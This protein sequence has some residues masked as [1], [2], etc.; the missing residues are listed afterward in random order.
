MRLAYA[1]LLVVLAASWGCERESRASE[2][3]EKTA[4]GRTIEVPP[5]LAKPEPEP[6]FQQ[7]YSLVDNRHLAHRFD[8]HGLVMDLG[9]AG[10]LKYMQG[11]WNSTWYRGRDGEGFRYGQPRGVSGTLRF[12]LWVPSASAETQGWKLGIRL[13]PE[14]NQRCDLFIASA[15]G[16]ERKFASL[17]EIKEGWNEYVVDLPDGLEV[18]QEHSLRLHFSRSRGVDGRRVAASIDWI[19]IGPGAPGSEVQRLSKLISGD[20]IA[21]PAGHALTW[22]TQPASGASFSATVEGEVML[23]RDGEK[24]A[25]SSKRIALDPKPTRLTLAAQND[26]TIENPRFVT[27]ATPETR[28]PEKRPK[29]VLVWVIDTLRADHLKVYNSETDVETPNLDAWAE[30]AAVFESATC[31]GNSSLPTAAA[32]FSA[33]YAPN[34]G[35]NHD[36]ARL[37]SDV[38]L[39]GEAF[40][41]A[42][43]KTGL[44]SSN[45]YVSNTWGFARGF[46]AEVNP[47]RE[48]RPSDTEYL[49]PEARDW[50]AKQVAESPETP[51]LLYV[52]TIDP[53]VPYDPPGEIL[54]KYHQ[55]PRVGR[56]R[57]RAT[58]ELLHEMAKGAPKLNREESRY[59]HALYKGEITYNDVWF[60]KM[61]ADLEA[62]GIRDQTMIVVT[63]DHGEEFGEYGRWGHG[64]SVNQE[65]VDIPL[66]VGFEPWTRDGVR[67]TDDV[68]IVDMMPTLLDA[69]GIEIPDSVQGV[70]L[71]PLMLDVRPRHPR[72]AFAYHN[73]FLRSARVGTWKYQLFNGDQDPLF[74]LDG[75]QGGWDRGDQSDEQPVVR[76]M[77]RDLMAFQLALEEDLNKSR[78]GFP[79]HH[80][81][82]LARRLDQKHW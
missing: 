49:W 44:Y 40:K 25:L 71:V 74:K 21:L 57:P 70:S 55:G 79:N 31:Q 10:G 39:L 37:P 64:V 69:V 13:K 68:E 50:L 52:N 33:S 77:M 53:H 35:L 75:P 30:Q 26:S 60:G 12:P 67:I 22:Y 20:T 61:L 73:D 28:E 19:R 29:Y 14:G 72:P 82:T 51:A 78:D 65:L 17:H 42:S 15:D 32:I 66:I 36:K 81:E 1:L 63:S 45:G 5:A 62:L 47:I 11:R 80:S 56:V 76:R 46:D 58:G 18:G 48:K 9:E 38:V 6:E 24:E 59:M 27:A 7:S 43:W 4:S 16:E 8:S 34:H 23:M 54:A 41:N 3:V 2:P